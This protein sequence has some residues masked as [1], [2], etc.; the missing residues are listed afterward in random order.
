[1]LQLLWFQCTL[2]R[3]TGLI[4][5][6]GIDLLAS[7]TKTNFPH[8]SSTSMLEDSFYLS[9]ACCKIQFFEILLCAWLIKGATQCGII[10]MEA[11]IGNVK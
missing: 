9:H 8:A 4:E 5:V 2:T 6:S 3:D 11:W 10:C 7:H 1:M